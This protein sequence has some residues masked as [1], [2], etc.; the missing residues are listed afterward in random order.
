ML[1]RHSFGRPRGPLSIRLPGFGPAYRIFR[2]SARLRPVY[3][4]NLLAVRILPLVGILVLSVVGRADEFLSIPTGG[5]VPFGDV[6]L[7]FASGFNAGFSQSYAD[8]GIGK[9]FETTLR[10]ERPLDMSSVGTFDFA[11]NYIAPISGLIP[12]LSFGVQDGLDQTPEGRRF[13]AVLTSR[14]IYSTDTGDSPGDVTLGV[15]VGRRSGPFVGLDIPLATYLRLVACHDGYV[16]TAGIE[17]R[18][19]KRFGLRLVAVDGRPQIGL[20][21]MTRF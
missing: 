8:F 5:K 21:T 14:Q 12:G 1:K 19:N 2:I 9:S 15:F 13:Y 20:N 4:G 16:I 10:L 18:T 17:F 7:D 11:Y 3:R 6:R